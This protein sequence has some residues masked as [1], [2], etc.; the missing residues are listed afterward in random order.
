M[1]IARPNCTAHLR[2]QRARPTRPIM[3]SRSLFR[4]VSLGII[5]LILSGSQRGL[6]QSAPAAPQPRTTKRIEVPGLPSGG[7]RQLAWLLRYARQEQEYVRSTIRDFTCSVTKRERIEG[8]LQSFQYLKMEVREEQ[9]IGDRVVQ[10]LAVYV[11]FTAPAD[12]AGRRVLYVEGQNEG[13]LLVRRG[14]RRNP[15]LVVRIDPAGPAAMQES[16][17]PITETGFNRMLD[18]MVRLLEDHRR[19]DPTGA[20][21]R[22][23]KFVRAKIN[24]RSCTVLRVT[25]PN[26]QEGLHFH[27]TNVY[28]DDALH[29]P[30]RIDAYGWPT[31]EGES[32]PVLAEYTYTDLVLNPGLPA[33]SF[34]PARVRRP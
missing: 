6:A 27:I 34:D 13:R 4:S 24:G 18:R 31:K 21:T 12:V 30:V 28:V 16:Q 22:L 5:V 15:Y 19:I 11:E 26:E 3:A 7:N 29:V 9:R 10:P 23:Q 33:S 14:G 20:N 32:P 8:V 25:H 17:V 1:G 2:H